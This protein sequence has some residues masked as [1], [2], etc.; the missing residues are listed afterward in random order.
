[1]VKF[2]EYFFY[3]MYWYYVEKGKEDIG[4]E[5]L[6]CVLGMSFIQGFNFVVLFEFIRF[7]IL[8]IRDS[9][10]WF[11]WVPL[12]III[13]CNYMYFSRGGRKKRIVDYWKKA[14]KREKVKMDVMLIIYIAGTVLTTL[15]MAYMIRNNLKL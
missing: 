11:Y 6:S 5:T 15:C 9:N 13:I 8:G 14:P 12:T 3:R 4:N 7:L 1:M 2:Y 10:V